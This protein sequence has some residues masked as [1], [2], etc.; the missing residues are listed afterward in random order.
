[1]LMKKVETL[2]WFYDDKVANQLICLSVTS[3]Y[4][5]GYVPYLMHY[6]HTPSINSKY[7]ICLEIAGKTWL[8]TVS[9]FP[10]ADEGRLPPPN[11]FDF[12]QFSGNFDKIVCWRPFLDPPLIPVHQRLLP[13]QW[14]I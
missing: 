10:L 13:Y 9:E 8:I 11:S 12:V 1:M 2:W 5:S 4:K 6:I 3:F 14:W 7:I